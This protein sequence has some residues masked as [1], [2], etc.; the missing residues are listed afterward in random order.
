MQESA[1]SNPAS[2]TQVDR[3]GRTAPR[4]DAERLR[5][6]HKQITK[7]RED[8]AF[9]ARVQRLIARERKLL[10]RLR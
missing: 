7:R 6:L 8:H 1:G 10:D 2:S 3:G 5:E 4:D 9:T